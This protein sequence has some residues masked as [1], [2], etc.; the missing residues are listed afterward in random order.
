MSSLWFRVAG[1]YALSMVRQPLPWVAVAMLML[2]LPAAAG[3]SG[4]PM[5][6]WAWLVLATGVGW[7]RCQGTWLASGLSRSFMAWAR[8]VVAAV[9]V[10]LI[11]CGFAVLCPSGWHN[12]V[13]VVLPGLDYSAVSGSAPMWQH[14]VSLAFLGLCFQLYA[15][16]VD[17]E[18]STGGRGKGWFFGHSSLWAQVLAVCATVLVYAGLCV[19][20]PGIVAAVLAVLAVVALNRAVQAVRSLRVKR[21]ADQGV[22]ASEPL[23]SR[24]SRVAV[25]NTAAG[26]RSE[27]VLVD[28]MLAVGVAV[29][30]GLNYWFSSGRE[31]SSVASDATAVLLV[32]LACASLVG[33]G[34]VQGRSLAVAAGQSMS[35]FARR[36]G[37]RLA[38]SGGLSSL[39][40]GVLSFVTW[41]DVWAAVALTV[42]CAVSSVACGFATAS[43]LL[44]V[45]GRGGSAGFGVSGALIVLVVA[46]PPLSMLAVGGVD[47]GRSLAVWL[48]ALVWAV[49]AVVT[50]RDFGRQCRCFHSLMGVTGRSV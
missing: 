2:C 40:L 50:G 43:V 35:R 28:V 42:F 39:V 23:A 49:A 46:C 44:R 22:S 37:L 1:G 18:E 32:C 15:L 36:V 12:L 29:V 6:F 4:F 41:R 5:G 14:V 19:V 24:A 8:G 25:K 3:A 31:T 21:V 17:F 33:L 27:S 11:V 16:R 38:A 47:G 9:W 13:E 30:C 26:D 34:M 7:V 48:V 20:M 10:A 45:S